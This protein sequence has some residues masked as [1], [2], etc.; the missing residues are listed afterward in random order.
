MNDDTATTDTATD[1][2]APRPGQSTSVWR[3]TAETLSYLGVK[4]P[5]EADVCVVGAGI[6]G[7]T[8]AYLLAQRGLQVV[9]LDDGPVGGGETGQ[10]SAHLSPILGTRYYELESTHGADGAKAIADAHR[11]AIDLVAEIAAHEAPDCEFERLDGYL[12][13]G[14]GDGREELARE[15]AALGRAGIDAEL[16]DEARVGAMRL[17]P[18]L[19]V[20][21]QGRFHPLRYLAGLA[22][23]VE[24]MRGVIATDAHVVKVD[25]V[26]GGARVELANG[27]SLHAEH[28]VVATNSPIHTLLTYHTKIAPY[29]TY[30]VGLRVPDDSLPALVWD[31]EDPYHYLRTTR[32]ADGEVLLVGGRDHKTGQEEDFDARYAALEA[33]TRARFPAA[34]EVVIRWSGQVMESVDGIGYDGRSVGE[35]CAWVITG[36]SGNGL[37]NGTLG[38]MIVRDGVE[39]RDNPWRATFDPA[40]SPLRAAGE[41][42]RENANVAAQFADWLRGS[43][44]EGVDNIAPG[45]GA[46]LRHHLAQ[47]AVYRDD[48]GN[49]S[50]CSAVCPHAGCLVAWNS[51]EKSWD[52]PCHGSRFDPLG[53]VLNGPA[54]TALAPVAPVPGREEDMAREPVAA[55]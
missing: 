42:I 20:P 40:R 16:V 28:V 45:E 24:R 10:T 34:G 29:R 27:G 31:T 6:A 54:V 53:K 32:D 37:T 2:A 13:P 21:G 46:V 3:A 19:R 41:W 22:R 49:L 17:G 30:V 1:S 15:L 26:E 5:S 50:A 25:A 33:W 48:T 52:C 14:E 51:A 39:G 38:A 44:V 23:G 9:V 55:K 4:V 7:L 36:D 18:A 35:C 47:V 12:I 8:A 11:A 43:D